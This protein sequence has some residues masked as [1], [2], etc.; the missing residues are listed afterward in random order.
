M[1]FAI[2]RRAGRDIACFCLLNETYYESLDAYT[3]GSSE[4]KRII[5]S[6]LPSGWTLFHKGIWYYA[7]PA[8]SV[9][10]LQGFKIHLSATTSS[11]ENLLKDVIPLLVTGDVAFKLVADPFMLDYVNS[12]NFPRGASGKF[13]TI[14]PNN[15]QHFR[16]LIERLYDATS[17]RRGPYILSDKRYCDSRIVFYRYGGFTPRHKM[18]IFGERLPIISD[19]HG[20][21]V[22]DKRLP[23]FR[24]PEGIADPFDSSVNR[25]GPT[26]DGG[27]LLKERYLVESA[28][29]FSNSG[30]VYKGV[31]QQT[32][33]KILIK[34]ARPYISTTRHNSHDAVDTLKKEA[35]VLDLLEDTGLAPRRIDCF[36]A[37]DHYF[38]VEEYVD[39][40]PFYSYRADERR[41]L[42]LGPV[43]D[44][45][46]VLKFCESF[47]KIGLNLM[48]AL[49]VFHSRGIIFGDL[50]PGNI[51][52][53]EQTHELTIVDFECACFQN[54]TEQELFAPFTPG[55]ISAERLHGK[56]LSVTDDYYAAG[57]ILYSL[58]IPVTVL[59]DLN[60]DAKEIFLDRISHEY[61]L[62]SNI[63]RAIQSLM[64]G[65]VDRARELLSSAQMP[66]PAANRLVGD[67]GK[68]DLEGVIAGIIRYIE[69]TAEYTRDDRFWPADYRVF[70]T[71]PLSISFGALGILLFLKQELGAIPAELHQWITSQISKITNEEFPPGLYVGLSGIAWALSE[72]G[73]EEEAV[74]TMKTAYHS[75][76]LFEGCDVFYGCAGIGLASLYFW[77]RTKEHCFLEQ[78]RTL[79]NHLLRTSIEDEGGVQW[80]NV[81]GRC[82][83]GYAHG[84]SGI[85]LFLLYLYK[86]T[87]E[88]KYLEYAQ[89]GIEREIARSVDRDGAL[90]WA[91]SPEDNI[92]FPYWRFGSSGV[93][94]VLIRFYDVLRID[95]YR[96][97][98]DRAAQYGSGK[99]A[100]SPG[101]F[102]GLS[103]IGELLLDM[104][105]FTGSRRYMDEAY[106]VVRKILLYQIN[107][108]RGIAFPG[109][110]LMRI[111]NDV[112]TGSAGIGFFFS[113]FLKPGTRIFFDFEIPVCVETGSLIAT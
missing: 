34:E 92:T 14:Y 16:N 86:A 96:E 63:G 40:F 54:T 22:T 2:D 76:L 32:G 93:G 108:E 77:G 82:Y 42:I 78:A 29:T 19:G 38:L 51:L 101:Q 12:K 46:R 55:F 72:L 88:S 66:K 68:Q 25:P 62:P 64:E 31:D 53:D 52:I 87:Q 61:G 106:Q 13:I 4:Y 107:T 11:A 90:A 57:S 49:E 33:R 41:A 18:S 67:I 3:P 45:E 100:V 58:I 69:S 10:T 20:M 81:D 94:S 24:L 74:T 28:I 97:L 23:A 5:D 7:R 35:Q 1:E 113:R 47:C 59:F 27:I 79:G 95:R 111:S 70:L 17:D 37:W 65:S 85:A 44:H 80:R 21:E 30:G 112:A 109:E 103:G 56:G 89:L 8:S 26:R 75:Q 39:G 6:C 43:G 50:S 102:Y 105:H 73:L 104:Y 98:A 99:Y 71:N 84:A 9:I 83:C 48:R 91:R 60:P 110:S 15:E 36:H